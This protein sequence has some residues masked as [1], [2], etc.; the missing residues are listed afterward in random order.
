MGLL[1]TDP[2]L[3]ANRDDAAH[4]FHAIHRAIKRGEAA[5]NLDEMMTQ[6]AAKLTALDAEVVSRL[7]AGTAGTFKPLDGDP[8][9]GGG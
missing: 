3:A 9:P 8:K 5:E 4:Y 1:M 7:N 2:E 6:L